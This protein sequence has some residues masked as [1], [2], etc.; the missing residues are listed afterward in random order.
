VSCLSGSV[1]GAGEADAV[2][3]PVDSLDEL[4]ALLDRRG[5]HVS[6]GADVPPDHAAFVA[7]LVVKHGSAEGHRSPVGIRGALLRDQVSLRRGH[8]LEAHRTLG[9]RIPVADCAAL[10]TG[11]AVHVNQ[12]RLPRANHHDFPGL[13]SSSRFPAVFRCSHRSGHLS[14]SR[15]RPGVGRGAGLARSPTPLGSPD[16]PLTGCAHAE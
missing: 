3:V 16:Q 8:A 5:R 10:L 15:G 1:V 4:G 7:Q 6:A 11:R 14:R 2:S 13:P 12:Y 9:P